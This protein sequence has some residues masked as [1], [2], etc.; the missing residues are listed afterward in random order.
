MLTRKVILGFTFTSPVSRFLAVNVASG[1]VRS[2]VVNRLLRVMISSPLGAAIPRTRGQLVG[3]VPSLVGDFTFCLLR[4]FRFDGTN[5]VVE[6]CAVMTI[7]KL[8]V[9]TQHQ[10]VHPRE[11]VKERWRE[12]Q[13]GGF[14][15][16]RSGV[17]IPVGH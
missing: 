1:I 5:H 16:V 14:I 17:L 15:V 7:T 8:L 2:V 4:T 6:S 9:L 3:D 13:R 10:H 12:G 11:H